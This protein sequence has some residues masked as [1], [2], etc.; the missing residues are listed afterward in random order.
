MRKIWQVFLIGLICFMVF[1][2]KSEA[3]SFKGYEKSPDG[4]ILVM[5][6]TIDE[7]QETEKDFL[8]LLSRHAALYRFPKVQDSSRQVRI[9][10]NKCIKL[11]ATLI[12]HIDAVTAR[13]MSIEDPER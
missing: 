3:S 8:I 13:I 7:F 12:V 11:K 1:N 4:E 2:L 9:F 5:N 6:E 10:L